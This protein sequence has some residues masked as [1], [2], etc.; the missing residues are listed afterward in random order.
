MDI[1]VTSLAVLC[2]RFANAVLWTIVCIRVIQRGEP[3]PKIVRNMCATVLVLGGTTVF[4]FPGEV[5]RFLYTVFTAY[6]AIIA[7]AI[8]TE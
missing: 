7:L 4:G 2:V 8:V 3:L 6:A 1:D 5:A